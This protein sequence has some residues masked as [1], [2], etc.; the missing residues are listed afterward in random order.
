MYSYIF[1]DFLHKKGCKIEFHPT[2]KMLIFMFLNR[3]TG[4]SW[5]Q[6]SGISLKQ[7]RGLIANGN[8]LIMY[9]NSDLCVYVFCSIYS[10]FFLLDLFIKNT[11]YAHI[12]VTYKIHDLHDL[13]IRMEFEMVCV[14]LIWLNLLNVAQHLVNSL[15]FA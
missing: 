3:Q 8:S 4:Q 1:T 10:S 11:M 13:F 14:W 7:Y 15:K 12:D 5:H 9:S 2:C 6:N